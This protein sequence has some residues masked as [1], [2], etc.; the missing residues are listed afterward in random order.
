MNPISLTSSIVILAFFRHS[1]IDNV[2]NSCV[3]F[4]LLNLSSSHAATRFPPTVRHAE[5]S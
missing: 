1:L 4:F 5:E 2:G 3:C